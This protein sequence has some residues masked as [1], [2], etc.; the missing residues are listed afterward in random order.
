MRSEYEERWRMVFF[1]LVQLTWI[2]ITDNYQSIINNNERLLWVLAGFMGG[3]I[4]NFFSYEFSGTKWI[5]VGVISVATL[6]A[7]FF[8]AKAAVSYQEESQEKVANRHDLVSGNLALNKLILMRRLLQTHQ[9]N[10]NRYLICYP[11]DF[12]SIPPEL[13]GSG[14]DITIDTDRIAFLFDSEEQSLVGNIDIASIRYHA[15]LRSIRLR[16]TFFHDEILSKFEKEDISSAKCSPE[17]FVEVAGYKKTMTLQKHTEDMKN[18]L[19]ENIPMLTKTI[20]KLET[21]LEKRFP[22]KVATAEIVLAPKQD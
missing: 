8:G 1:H 15:T 19:T 11:N 21:V 7:A 2:K 20:S 4:F 22:G 17:K 13:V 12:M 5:E 14:S 6:A 16:G 10:I 9:V 18:A 3:I